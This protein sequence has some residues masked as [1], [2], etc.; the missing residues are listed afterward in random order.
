MDHDNVFCH[1]QHHHYLFMKSWWSFW[2]ECWSSGKSWRCSR[3]FEAAGYQSKTNPKKF[4]EIYSLFF[5]WN[6]FAIRSLEYIS[7][8]YFVSF[9][10]GKYDC[11]LSRL[12]QKSL[13]MILHFSI[14]FSYK[15][16]HFSKLTFLTKRSLPEENMIQPREDNN[17]VEIIL[18][19]QI[20][21]TNWIS[22]WQ[23]ITTSSST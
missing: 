2:W 4:S 21:M 8:K 17:L 13:L 1:C 6:I 3:W 18:K 11:H 15:K 23:E 19:I 7:N 10:E 12:V 22:W 16:L 14:D 9:A 20:M 5:L